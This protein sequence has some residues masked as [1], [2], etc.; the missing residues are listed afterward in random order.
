VENIPGSLPANSGWFL[1]QI[2]RSAYT[3]ETLFYS[4]STTD[5]KADT[6]PG[7]YDA[8]LGAVVGAG[9]FWRHKMAC[10]PFTNCR[11]YFIYNDTCKVQRLALSNATSGPFNPA[12]WSLSPCVFPNGTTAYLDPMLGEAGSKFNESSYVS[13]FPALATDYPWYGSVESMDPEAHIRRNFYT[14]A[15]GYGADNVTSYF[16][17]KNTVAY[18][19]EGTVDYTPSDSSVNRDLALDITL[20]L[21]VAIAVLCGILVTC[22]GIYFGLRYLADVTKKME[23]IARAKA[24]HLAE[25]TAK[26]YKMISA[27]K[28]QQIIKERLDRQEV[29]EIRVDDLEIED[30]LA[31]FMSGA[32]TTAA[33]KAG[34][35]KKKKRSKALLLPEE[36]LEILYVMD[37]NGYT[38]GNVLQWN[39]DDMV[40]VWREEL[41]AR[42][43]KEKARA[44]HEDASECFTLS[45]ENRLSDLKG[46]LKKAPVDPLVEQKEHDEKTKAAKEKERR[47]AIVSS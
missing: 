47:L 31:G 5:G 20:F 12:L 41:D 25:C 10:V 36:K 23:I 6:A 37:V 35:G 33:A 38:A 19:K 43:V 28:E 26:L 29:K 11:S 16:Y 24:L 1:K 7:Y 2:W 15:N 27:E 45:I 9:A 4:P 39:I 18:G 30:E 42:K 22:F 32:P 40:K 46:I 14:F 21:S 17:T 44:R 3:N 34:D 13:Q 8:D